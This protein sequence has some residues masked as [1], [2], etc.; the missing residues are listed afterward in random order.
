MRLQLHRLQTLDV[1]GSS[2][3]CFGREFS[4]NETKCWQR[5]FFKK[6]SG[7]QNVYLFWMA[8]EIQ[9]KLLP[10]GY[11]ELRYLNEKHVHDE[12]YI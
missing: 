10:G 5:L 9:R 7:F 8:R 2:S 4:G 3:S 1:A 12:R 6:M 11:V